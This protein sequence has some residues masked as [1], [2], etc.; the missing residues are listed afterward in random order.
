MPAK[1]I[2]RA[3]TEDVPVLTQILACLLRHDQ[4]RADLCIKAYLFIDRLAIGCKA[5]LVFVFRLG[6]E[7]SDES[8]MEI[9]NLIG[10]RRGSVEKNC[11]ERG[12][13]ASMLSHKR[14]VLRRQ[15]ARRINSLSSSG[16]ANSWTR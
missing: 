3:P 13:A 8:I 12:V 5:L 4:C 16:N 1:I 9:E 11:D 14:K 6:E 10:Q 7:G 15:V 2:R